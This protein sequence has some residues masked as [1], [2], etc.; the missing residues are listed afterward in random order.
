MSEWYTPEDMDI[1]A[2]LRNRDNG[3]GCKKLPC[4][5][6]PE[7]D[8]KELE[9]RR[10]HGAVIN[11]VSAN[12]GVAG[13]AC[14][15]GIAGLLPKLAAVAVLGLCIVVGMVLEMPMKWA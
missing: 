9:S 8:A 4:V 11:P 2:V 7:E 5:I 1:Q 10:K 13:T 12:Y 6:I 14:V 15:L 3:T